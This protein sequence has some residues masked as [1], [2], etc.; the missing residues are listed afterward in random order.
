MVD[1][2]IT[3]SILPDGTI[4]SI[5]CSAHYKGFCKNT[6][7]TGMS[8]SQI[9]NLTE[10]QRIFNGVLI[11]NEDFGLCYVLPPPYDEMADSTDNIPQELI[12]NEIYISDFSSWVNKTK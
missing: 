10:R 4:F 7:S 1:G 12:L 3:I 2:T 5:G 8:F 11:L 6:L 9:K